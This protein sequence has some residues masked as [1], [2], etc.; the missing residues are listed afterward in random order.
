MAN[1]LKNI[2]SS[3]GIRNANNL[4]LPAKGYSY[5]EGNARF[6]FNPS[7]QGHSRVNAWW[8]A[9]CAL[10]A[11]E[12]KEN[13]EANLRKAL[14]FD[15]SSLTWFDNHSTGLDGFGICSKDNDFAILSFRGTEFYPPEEILKDIGKV[16][17][18]GQDIIQDLKLRTETFIGP[19]KFDVPVVKGFYQQLES[20]WAKLKFWIEALPKT[21]SLWL[22]G[23]SL[24]AAIVLLLAYQFP[25]RVAGVYTF[26]CP[27]PGKQGFA[28][29]FA[30]DQLDLNKRTFRYVHGNDL[31]AK[32]LEFPLSSYRHIGTPMILEAASRKNLL[33]RGWGWLFGRDI[34]DHAPLYYALHCWN[35]VPESDA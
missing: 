32:G 31:I 9:E 1:P 33:E 34:T 19:P 28:D 22:T 26:G 30:P 2:P 5:F 6:P 16:V 17:T 35:L 20:D 4:L 13:I 15:L 25:D 29:A 11:Y 23:H 3:F 21:R 12:S 14:P 8:L 7:A 10:L 27:C 24:G 18:V